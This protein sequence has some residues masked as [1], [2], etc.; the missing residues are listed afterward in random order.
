MIQ[1]LTQ[2]FYP[3]LI[4]TLKFR[5]QQL[6]QALSVLKYDFIKKPSHFVSF[7]LGLNF[8]IKLP[9][10]RCLC[11]R[12]MW[13]WDYQNKVDNSIF[14]VTWLQKWQGNHGTSVLVQWNKATKHVLCAT[15]IK[16]YTDLNEIQ[17]RSKG[18]FF[19]FKI[20]ASLLALHSLWLLR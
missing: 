1:F 15:D 18:I 12:K 16:V 19:L 7:L 5:M 6:E 17:F 11:N 14:H 10:K 20:E 3:T 8:E 13:Y 2:F 4:S 9:W